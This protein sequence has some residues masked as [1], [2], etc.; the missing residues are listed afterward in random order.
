MSAQTLQQEISELVAALTHELNNPLTAIAGFS[1]LAAQLT[2]PARIQ[3]MIQTI[4]E[5]SGKCQAILKRMEDTYVTHK[6]RPE[7]I[8]IRSLLEQVGALHKQLLVRPNIQ[9]RIEVDPS[10]DTLV[11]DPI[12]VKRAVDN[13]IDNAALALDAVEPAEITVNTRCQDGYG[14]ISIVDNGTGIPE[15]DL[16]RVFEPTFT[17]HSAGLALGLGLPAVLF[18]MNAHNGQVELENRPDGGLKVELRFRL[19]TGRSV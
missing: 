10:F 3:T 1:Q 19:N 18:I 4:R 7:T 2:D 11:A 12:L 6:V 14:I 8:E 16:T 9:L 17:T 5:E 13:L 15:D